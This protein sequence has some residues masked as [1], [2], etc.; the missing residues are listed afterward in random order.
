[1]IVAYIAYNHP[2]VGVA[3]LVAV[4]VVTL[5]YLLTGGGENGSPPGS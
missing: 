3:V 2:E 1:M 5:L 4:G